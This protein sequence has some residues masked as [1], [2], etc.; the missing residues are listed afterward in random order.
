[1]QDLALLLIQEETV[2]LDDFFNLLPIR[3]QLHS[4]SVANLSVK[5]LSW[6]NKEG[7]CNEE[8]VSAEELYKAAYYHDVGMAFIPIPLVEK[9]MDLTG[10]EYRVLQRHASYGANLIERYREEQPFVEKKDRVWRLAAEI[11]MSHHERWDGSGY[12]SH[13]RA[14]AIHIAAR[15]VAIADA[16]DTIVRGSPYCM[17]LSPA[18]GVLELMENANKQFDPELIAV[19]KKHYDELLLYEPVQSKEECAGVTWE[20]EVQ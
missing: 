20:E 5:I 17:P 8:M 6:A 13:L 10:V 11:A 7:V 15:I 19:I 16:F 4:Q 9:K 18:Y 2:R 1:M 3:M 14:T 12:P